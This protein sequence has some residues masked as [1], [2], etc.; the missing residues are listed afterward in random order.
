MQ[1]GPGRVKG[2]SPRW[3]DAVH[4]AVVTRTTVPADP[5][6][7]QHLEEMTLGPL[8]EGAPGWNSHAT[9]CSPKLIVVHDSAL[10]A[11]G[12]GAIDSLD[13]HIFQDLEDMT[14][15][16]HMEG[17][18]LMELAALVSVV[19]LEDHAYGTAIRD[20]IESFRGEP[21]ALASVYAALHRLKQRGWLTVTR[22]QPLLMPGGRHR[23]HYRLSLT[24]RS[25]LMHERSQLTLMLQLLPRRF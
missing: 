8:V 24:G 17:R 21:V 7:F 14:L 13:R 9:V 2:R 15:E 1:I 23:R 20:D 4:R 12:F 22:S 25:E 16:T 10:G 18:T 3:A 11:S 6:I 19:R 5:H